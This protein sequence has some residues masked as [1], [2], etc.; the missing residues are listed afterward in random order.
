MILLYILSGFI[1]TIVSIGIGY[2]FGY[3]AGYKND[4]SLKQQ[5]GKL[6][7]T[8]KTQHKSAQLKELTVAELQQREDW[9]FRAKLAQLTNTPV[10]TADR[11][12]SNDPHDMQHMF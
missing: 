12:E 10:T 7:D 4:K 3:Q 8:V 11:E 1:I 6:Q 5:I 9:D 2:M